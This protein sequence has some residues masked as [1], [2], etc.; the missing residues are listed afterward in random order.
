MPFPPLDLFAAVVALDAP[1]FFRG[2]DTLTDLPPAILTDIP[3]NEGI[4]RFF[5]L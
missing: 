3:E 2:F 1:R 4:R 5:A